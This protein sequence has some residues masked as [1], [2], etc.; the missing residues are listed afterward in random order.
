MTKEKQKERRDKMRSEGRCIRCGKVKEDP[1]YVHCAECRIK[2]RADKA[3]RRER[4]I[5]RG[6]GTKCGKTKAVEGKQM[7][8]A[9]AIDERE[10]QRQKREWFKLNHICPRCGKNTLYGN[11]K[12]CGECLEKD[13]EYRNRKARARDS[14]EY[15]R[16]RREHRKDLGI[17]VHCGKRPAKDG[18]T[19]CDVCLRN[20]AIRERERRG[21]F[22]HRSEYPDYGICYQCCKRPV[23]NGKRLCKEC[24]ERSAKS[25]PIRS[26]GY[27]YWKRENE[28]IFIH[29]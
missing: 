10:K 3:K 9:C 18:K 8:E 29:P 5:E 12:R 15:D 16:E 25:L 7:C 20:K 24:S 17:C 4:Q 22:I 28:Y 11:E 21:H 13:R 19:M 23:A 2:D 14:T 26:G 6:I 27:E 1:T